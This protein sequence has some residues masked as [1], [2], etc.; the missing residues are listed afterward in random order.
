MNSRAS[1]HACLAAG[2]V[3]VFPMVVAWSHDTG[4]SFPPALYLPPLLC[5]LPQPPNVSADAVGLYTKMF[6]VNN[7]QDA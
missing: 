7:G 3:L 4:T 6:G 2:P 5:F 1:L